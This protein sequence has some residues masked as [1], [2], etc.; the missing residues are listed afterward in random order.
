MEKIGVLKNIWKRQLSGFYNA[1][2]HWECL[3]VFK[4]SLFENQFLDDLNR[5]SRIQG[6]IYVTEKILIKGA[7]RN[8]R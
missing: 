3:S 7:P 2:D 6:F 4:I 1:T 8:I 5:D